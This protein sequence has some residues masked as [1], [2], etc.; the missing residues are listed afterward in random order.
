MCWCSPSLFFLLRRWDVCRVSLNPY[1]LSCLVA[2]L[3]PLSG[4]FLIFSFG[5]AFF[6]FYLVNKCDIAFVL[7]VPGFVKML[8]SFETSVNAVN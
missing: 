1:L 4:S 7:S 5:L 6:F 2:W 8:V 3:Y